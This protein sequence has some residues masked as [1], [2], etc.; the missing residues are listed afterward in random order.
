MQP[1]G[2]LSSG[3]INSGKVLINKDIG[4][5]GSRKLL[6]LLDLSRK[7][8][9]ILSLAADF[10]RSALFSGQLCP[11]WRY[12][13]RDR[14]PGCAEFDWLDV[15]SPVILSRTLISVEKSEK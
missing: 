1:Y 5:R 4:G 14:R 15:V 7:V 9:K 10:E 3:K 2:C 13:A 6:F 8:V 12:V 11:I